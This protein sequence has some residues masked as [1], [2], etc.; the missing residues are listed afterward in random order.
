MSLLGILLALGR[1]CQLS[2]FAITSPLGRFFSVS[3]GLIARL[4]TST[5]NEDSYFT[6]TLNNETGRYILTIYDGCT[7]TY[8][9]KAGICR[10][11]GEH[12]H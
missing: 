12:R 10:R 2:F 1:C 7:G 3:I 5:F 4:Q 6:S 11:N 8:I 9:S